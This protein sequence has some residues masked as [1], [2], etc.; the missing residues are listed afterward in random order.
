M[1][2]GGGGK[3]TR[4]AEEGVQERKVKHWTCSMHPQVNRKTNEGF[5]PICKMELIPVYEDEGGGT[6]EEGMA[7]HKQ[8][9]LTPTAVALAEVDTTAVE[10]KI[11]VGEVRMVVIAVEQVFV[12]HQSRGMFVDPPG[13]ATDE[14]HSFG[15]MT[16]DVLVYGEI[17]VAH[18]RPRISFQI[19]H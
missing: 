19:L 8:I 6:S 7:S 12:T 4:S 3:E 16:A 15:K 14:T 10:Q 13:V 17:G 9:K 18:L 5:C 1:I 11:V 2:W